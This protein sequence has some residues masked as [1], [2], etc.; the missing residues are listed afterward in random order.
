MGAEPL[1]SEDV[2]LEAVERLLN[3]VFGERL[4]ALDA[5]PFSRR[6]LEWL[7]RD[8]PCGH[9]VAVNLV[10]GDACRAHYAVVPQTWRR[11]ARTLPMSLSLNSAV[12]EAS[13]GKGAFTRTARATYEAARARGI[14][15]VLGVGNANSTHGLVKSLGFR[16]IAPLPVRVGVVAPIRARGVS[17]AGVDE[18]PQALFAPRAGSWEQAWDR[19]TLRWRL[20]SPRA[21]DLLHHDGSGAIVSCRTRHRGAPVAVIL[22]TFTTPGRRL[23]IGRLLAA[24]AHGHRTALYL[25]GGWNGDAH[26]P[27]VPIP[28]RLLPAP[29]NLTYLPLDAT[30]PDTLVPRTYELLDFDAY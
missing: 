17:L 9:E 20:A 25:Y 11:G 15:G 4:R 14:V 7:Y 2:D 26:V 1:L 19:E 21:R 28:R 10:D 23:A 5:L 29:L 30:A 18:L 24:A 8:N 13:R 27:G 16:F 3:E 12:S 6:Y 22:K